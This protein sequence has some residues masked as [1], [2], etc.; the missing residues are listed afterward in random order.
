MYEKY[1]I[2]IPFLLILIFITSSERSSGLYV[3]NGVDQTILHKVA[4]RKQ[5]REVED[6]LLNLFELPKRPKRIARRA[7]LVKRSAPTFLLNIYKNILSNNKSIQDEH[8]NMDEFNLTNHDINIIDQSDLIMTF[9]AHNPHSGNASKTNRGK[10]IWFDVSE[11]PRG[12]RIIAA[13]LRL[14]Q[15]LNMNAQFNKTYAIALYRVARTKNGGRIKHYINSAN[16]TIAVYHADYTGR[17][18]RPEDIGIVGV[19]GAPHK[20]PF[21]VGFFKNSGNR[22]KR[23]ITFTQKEDDTNQLKY[24]LRNINFKNNPY[25]SR[26]VRR[27]RNT[28]NMKTLYVNFKDLQW[29]DWIIAPEGYDA[30]YCSGECNFPLNLHVNATNHAIVQTL[31]HL[32]KPKEVPKPCCAPTKLSSISVLYFLDDSNVVLKKYRNMVINSCGC[33]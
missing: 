9:G 27:N 24:N 5:K 15:S 7:L 25:T 16:T 1:I 2:V 19:L 32:M 3:D 30:Y 12:E 6:K 13:E 14:Y 18:M 17:I 23:D 10:R 4:N 22:N 21:M 28:C 33:H 8:N 20:Q 26:V 29:Q 31:V 11:V